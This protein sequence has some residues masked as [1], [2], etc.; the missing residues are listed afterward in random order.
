MQ[1]VA[2]IFLFYFLSSLFTYVLI[3]SNRQ[4]MMLS[5]NAIVA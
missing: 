4:K 3:A 1:I 5:I 2:W